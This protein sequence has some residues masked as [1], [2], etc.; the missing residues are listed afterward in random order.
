MSEPILCPECGH[1]I[2]AHRWNG[3]WYEEDLKGLDECNL[4]STDVARAY[5]DERVREA[6]ESLLGRLPEIFRPY[7]GNT[8]FWEGYINAV[9]SEALREAADDI[10]RRINEPDLI[11]MA[12][13][14]GGFHAGERARGQREA[15]VLRSRADRIEHDGR[16]PHQKCPGGS[17][18][19]C[20]FEAHDA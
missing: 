1:D 14:Y 8:E 4:S 16:C 13:K 6:M 2:D 17:L 19:C 9:K 20:L 11:L 7:A 12:D 18:C 10:E 5:A 15:D 3:C